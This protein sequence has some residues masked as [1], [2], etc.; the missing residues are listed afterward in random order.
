MPTAGEVVLGQAVGSVEGFQVLE[1]RIV[2]CASESMGRMVFK[3]TSL[4]LRG[5]KDIGGN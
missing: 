2:G 3:L 5:C 4:V 1:Q